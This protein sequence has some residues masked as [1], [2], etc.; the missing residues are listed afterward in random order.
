M[1]VERRVL[2]SNIITRGTA[3]FGLPQPVSIVPS[4]LKL[5]PGLIAT[6][7]RRN[8]QLVEGSL[9]LSA[10][11]RPLFVL[12]GAIPIYRD[13]V[14]GLHGEDVQ[15]LEQALDRLEYAPG[16]VDGHFDAA[17]SAALRRWYEAAGWE[18]F[19][20]TPE[21]LGALRALE[22]DYDD[23]LKAR[24]VAETALASARLD[25]GAARARAE[26]ARSAA[27]AEL[28]A[29]RNERRRLASAGPQVNSLSV[30]AAKAQSEHGIQV[31]EAEL[32]LHIK[33]RAQIVLDPRQPKTARD[34]AEARVALAR[35]ALERARL[36]GQLAIQKATRELQQRPASEASL[37]AAIRS[38]TAA[39]ESARLDGSK[40][41]GSAADAVKLA[42]YDVELTG[43]RA[44]R[45]ADQLD[46]MRARLGIQLPSD[47]LVFLPS[48]PVRVEEVMAAI[49]DA[50][51]GP[52]LKVTDN[53]V[54]VDS[55]LPLDAAPLVRPGMPVQIDEQALGIKAVGKVARVADT[56]GTNGV[57]GF[58]IYFEVAVDETP[59]RLEGFSLRLTIPI[60]STRGEVIAVPLSAIS[61]AP[62][63]TSRLRRETANGELEYV[64]VEPGMSADGYVEVNAVD[65]Q[66]GTDDMVV[67]GFDSVDG[68]ALP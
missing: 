56:P 21:Q 37:D 68:E 57:D 12:Q 49:G 18:P 32:A 41:M 15:Q 8:A 65:Q 4:G 46:R 43:N 7:P 27:E 17:T 36:E 26:S 67:I 33:E 13:L 53:Q 54:S 3:R 20:P 5:A 24:L 58:H 22:R 39:L 63:G 19:A 48:L 30:D 47:E 34:A 25:V 23:A 59:Q 38:A 45:L 6:V 10:S 64:T 42:E 52:V 60:E 62:D 50:A 40:V 1:P 14:P 55:A 16:E 28:Q 9:V 61:L 35:A 51:A 66:L 44:Q 31:A 2:S 11:G 29:R